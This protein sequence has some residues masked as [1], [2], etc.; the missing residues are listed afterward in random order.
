MNR[1]QKIKATHTARAEIMSNHALD[2]MNDHLVQRRGK[3]DSPELMIEHGCYLQE[4]V[5]RR[6]RSH[7][8]YNG[9]HEPGQGILRCN[10][11]PGWRE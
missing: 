7:P 2:E 10:N 11:L 8:Q 6:E 4:I 5:A 9:W 1:F 3:Q